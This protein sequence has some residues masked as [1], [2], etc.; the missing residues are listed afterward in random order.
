MT[1]KGL[2]LEI[3]LVKQSDSIFLAPLNCKRQKGDNC[4]AISLLKMG[5][6]FERAFSDLRTWKRFDRIDLKYHTEVV[7]VKEE[8]YFSKPKRSFVYRHVS[9]R[10]RTLLTKSFSIS[11]CY[12]GRRHFNSTEIVEEYDNWKANTD[13]EIAIV[14]HFDFVVAALLFIKNTGERIF[15]FI[16]SD[17]LYQAGVNIMVPDRN[18][19][20]QHMVQSCLT[21]E[22][23]TGAEIYLDR[24]TKLIGAGLSV[25]VSL[26]KTDKVDY[27]LHIV[28]ITTTET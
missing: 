3:L 4:F 16:H 13:G 26:R 28:D 24:V 23:E 27:I 21:R 12:I 18:Q 6:H 14:K 15:L 11:H 22:P 17:G 2:R 25:S 8:D 19:Q 20:V 5:K 10:C 9:I 1:N 7:Y